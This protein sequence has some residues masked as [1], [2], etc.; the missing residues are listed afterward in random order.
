MRPTLVFV[1]LIA[2]ACTPL[3][4]DSA[5]RLAQI[6]GKLDSVATAMEQAS[7][8]QLSTDSQIEELKAL[9]AAE[10]SADN[11]AVSEL[12]ADL[13]QLPKALAKVC[14]PATAAR[15]PTCPPAAMVVTSDDKVLVGELEHVRLD[16]P[17]FDVV[18]RIDTGASSSSLHAINIVGFERDGDDWVRFSMSYDEK[19]KEVERPVVRQVRVIQQADKD[20]QVRP[21]VL[22]RVRIGNI[23]DSFEF[24]LADR[25][26][27]NHQLILGRNFLTDLAVVDVARQ[28]VQ[29]RIEAPKEG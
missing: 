14:A 22:M 5:R 29:P 21:V 25:S 27:L 26:H 10:Q 12:R 13:G 11:A 2:T 19:E 28:F 9:V 6:D 3:D 1:A 15:A 24:T 23:N 4:P 8:A 17:G 7:A 16:P 20:G 18:A